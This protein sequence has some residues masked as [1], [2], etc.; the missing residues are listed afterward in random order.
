M[1]KGLSDS[2]AERQLSQIINF[3]QLE[4]REK[5]EEIR[6]K[7]RGAGPIPQ[8]VHLTPREHVHSQA[9]EDY[10]MERQS[11]ELQAKNKLERVFA[12]M[13]VERITQRR[14]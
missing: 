13:E 4:A 3:I 8:V 1:A 12:Q 9:S 10:E 11:R 14:V 2:Q 5:A 7:V 6:A